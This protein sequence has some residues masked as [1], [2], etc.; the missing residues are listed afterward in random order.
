MEIRGILAR[1]IL[2]FALAAGI[3][4]R[5]ANSRDLPL[6]RLRLPAGFEITAF[7]AEV[8]NASSLALGPKWRSAG[9]SLA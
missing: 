1:L 4:P 6:N 9:S 7:V 3:A 5:I 8:P 2:S